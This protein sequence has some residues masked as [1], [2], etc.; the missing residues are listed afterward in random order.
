MLK[1]ISVIAPVSR[2]I[3]TTK[4]L[5]FAP[6]D[7]LKWLGLGFT[8]WLALLGGN[9]NAMNGNLF[10]KL[11]ALPFQMALEWTMAHRVLVILLAV[12]AGVFFLFVSLVVSWVSSRGKF[13]FMEN[14]VRDQSE[15]IKPWQ[16]N[17]AQGNSYFLFSIAFA[18]AALATLGVIL[19]ISALV[20]MPDITRH[21]FEA[22][23]IAAIILGGLLFGLYVI[24]LTCV[25]IFLDDFIVP[26][27]FLRS[28]RALA[29]WSEFFDLFKAHTGSFI[30]YV[31]FKILLGWA[32]G[33][34]SLIVFCCLCCVMW[35]PYV[36]TVMLLPLF[37][38]LRCYSLHF[39][40]QFGG[41]Y[42]VFQPD[43]MDYLPVA[44]EP[45]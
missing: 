28:C 39:L 20:A 4:Q 40:E 45:L 8:A 14:V 43:S 30:L 42:R 21:H 26:L 11:V 25:L 41:E 12:S 38:F 24:T 31:L 17:C 35:I 16:R 13:M 34:I 10:G 33:A 23:A 5:L 32:L 19:L 6:F 9:T 2:A 3:D 1:T 29:A 37:V 15:I 27:M 22:N 7:L 44:R 36:S 18:L